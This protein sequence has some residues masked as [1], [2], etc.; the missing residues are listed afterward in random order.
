MIGVLF[1][2]AALFWSVFEQAGSTLN[3]FADR[4]TR[5]V[6][7]RLDLPE[8][9]VPVDELAVPH[10]ASRRSSRGSGC[11]WR[12]RQR[13]VEPDQVRH[14][15]DPRRR[16]LRDPD[17]SRRSSPANGAQ[18]SP[19]WLTVTYLLHTCGELCLSPVGLSAM[20]K[21]APAR[22]GGLMM[23]VWFLGDLGRQLHR[24]PRLVVLRIVAAAEPVRRGRR[25]RDRRR[26][27]AAARSSK[28]IRRLTRDER[29]LDGR[30]AMVLE[31][32]KQK[33]NFTSTPE[34]AGDLEV[35]A[36]RARR[37]ARQAACSS[38]CRSTSPATC[39]T[40]SASNTTACCCRGRCRRDRRSIPKT[41]RLAMH[42]EDHPYRIRHVRRRHPGRLRR[43]HRDAVGPGHLDAASRTTSTRR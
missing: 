33:R 17:L 38:A 21:L 12:A 26:P 4:N 37:A 24:R 5:N 14:R 19:M 3:L 1:L 32:Y 30:V 22:I 6:G 7:L 27:R 25:V 43:R 35:A 34:P 40:T 11:A 39:T 15:P 20:T 28:P 42:V 36:A 31:K 16:R 8:Q 18:V 23:G 9:L 41:K 29:Q 10:H 2:A 13:T